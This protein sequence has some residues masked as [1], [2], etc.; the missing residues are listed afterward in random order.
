MKFWRGLDLPWD[1]WQVLGV[2]GFRGV[3]GGFRVYG[4]GV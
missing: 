1:L 3:E 4:L 2:S